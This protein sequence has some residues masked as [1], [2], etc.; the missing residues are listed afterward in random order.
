MVLRSGPYYM[1]LKFAKPQGLRR[2][3]A[4]AQVLCTRVPRSFGEED[5]LLFSRGGGLGCRFGRGDLSSAD[6]WGGSSLTFGRLQVSIVSM[7]R[8]MCFWIPTLVLN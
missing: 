1:V 3:R 5:D 4:S 2:V 7:P 6:F 8:L